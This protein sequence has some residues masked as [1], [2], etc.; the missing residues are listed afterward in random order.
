MALTLPATVF[1]V[2]AVTTC[3]LALAWSA[4]SDIRAYQIPNTA[5]VLILL[6]YVVFAFCAPSAPRLGALAVGLVVFAAGLFLFVRGS[7]G[8][9]DVKL[10]AAVSVW[11]GPHFLAAFAIVTGLT[12][13][14]LAAFLLSPLRRVMPRA[15]SDLL[16]GAEGAGLLR[17]PMPFGVAIAAGG[18]FVLVQQASLIR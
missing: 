17:Q 11:S 8:G 14:L 15:P 13:A 9:G 4:V 2:L 6:S 10:L 12:G 18:M 3:A 7:M 5:S 16:P 1:G